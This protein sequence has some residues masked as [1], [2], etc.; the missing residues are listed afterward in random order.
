MKKYKVAIV[1]DYKLLSQAIS[2]IV[3]GFQDFEVVETYEN[4]KDLVDHLTA[5]NKP[6]IVLMDI[7]MPQMNGIEAT[8]WLSK[9]YP[10][11]C[12]LALS[13]EDEELTIIDMIKAGAKGY[14]LK[15][16][17]KS[18]LENALK[19][20]VNSGVYFT[21]LVNDAMIH[22]VTSPELQLRE[23]DKTFLKLICTELTYKEIAEQMHVAAKTVDGYR[24]QLFV[25]LNDKNR[26]GLVLFAIKHKLYEI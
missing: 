8:K 1:E 18:T 23:S 22:S 24:D 26:I 10:D 20:I 9:N 5:E 2:S 15:D 13:V 17:D 25:K 14:L 11:I 7:N 12:V 6:D 21:K 19:S 3:N 16:V 4:G